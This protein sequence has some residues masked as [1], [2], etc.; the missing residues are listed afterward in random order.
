MEQGE[1]DVE[2]GGAFRYLPFVMETTSGGKQPLALNTAI[3]RSILTKF[4]KDETQNA[5]F[6]KVVLG[7]SGGVDSSLVAY[8]AAEALGKENVVGVML[9]YR[10]SQQAS[11]DDAA[12]VAK[13]LG[14]RS[15]T[16]EITPM[17]DPLIAREP[18][19]TSVRKGNVMARARMIVLYDISARENAL[20]IGTSN[21][22]ETLLGYGTLFGDTACAINPIGDLYKTQV[23]ELAE[24]VGVPKRIVEKKPTA[25]LWAGQ[26]DEEEL[27][28]SY[29]QVDRLLYLM[30]DERRSPQELTDAGFEPHFIEKVE[31]LIRRNQFKR[32]P[33][34]VAK[35][36]HRTVNVDFRYPRDWGM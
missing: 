12:L 26:T 29:K 28:F 14:I 30:I 10:T 4:I 11:H 16:V 5:G 35:I 25:D 21:K 22:T 8:L 31:R 36:S 15:E 3:V 18:G 32:R 19:M 2:S 6:S 1:R 7:L 23:W 27:G 20:V 13:E 33:P 34:V 17:V 9:P 24:A